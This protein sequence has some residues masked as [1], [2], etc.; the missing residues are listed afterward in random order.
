MN[1]MVYYEISR[2]SHFVLVFV[3][4]YNYSKLKFS[5]DDYNILIIIFSHLKY[6]EVENLY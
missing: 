2:K 5:K 1:Q 6:K 3:T 4:Q